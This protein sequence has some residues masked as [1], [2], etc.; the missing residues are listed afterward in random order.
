MGRD[1]TRETARGPVRSRRAACPIPAAGV[2]S[3]GADLM[4]FAEALRRGGELH[5]KRIVGPLTCNSPLKTTPAR[6]PTT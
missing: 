3:T 5:G 4:R 2:L 6:C 1:A